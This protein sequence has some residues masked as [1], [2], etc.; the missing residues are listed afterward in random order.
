M[1]VVG[2]RSHSLTT[3]GDGVLVLA[4]D[5]LFCASWLVGCSLWLYSTLPPTTVEEAYL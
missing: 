3:D 4:S 5:F 1:E 2:A